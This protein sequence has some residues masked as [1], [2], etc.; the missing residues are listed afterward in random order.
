MAKAAEERNARGSH[1]LRSNSTSN[2]SEEEAD[3]DDV[4]E[5]DAEESGDEGAA[6]EEQVDEY[7]GEEEQDDG[8]TGEEGRDDVDTGEEEPNDGAHVNRKRTASDLEE[9]AMVTVPPFAAGQRSWEV[10]EAAL[11]DYM[12]RTSQVLVVMENINIQ[13]RNKTLRA[14]KQYKGKRDDE[15]PLVPAVWK[16]YQRKY[17]CTHGWGER[18]RSKT[19]KR[20]FHKLRRDGCPFQFLAQLAQDSTGV[21]AIQ[22]RREDYRHNHN[23]GTNIHRHYPGIRQVPSKSPLMPGI[24]LLVEAQAG[25]SKIYDYI[26]GHSMHRVTMTD[27][28][29]LVNRIR[30][31]GVQLSDDDAV[32]ETVVNFNLE[33]EKNVSTDNENARGQTGVISFTTAHMRSTVDSFPEVVQMDCTHKTNK[34]NYQLLSIVAMDQFG[35]GQPVQYSLLETTSDWHISKAIDHFKRATEHWRLV[36][37]VIVDKDMTEVEKGKYGSYDKDVVVQLK[38]LIHNLTYA[39]TVEQYKF[40]KAWQQR[41]EEE[42]E[43]RVEM[44]GTLRNTGYSEEMNIVLDNG[45]HV[46]V[47]ND[48]HE[49]QLQKDGLLCDCEFAQTMK[50]PC[51]H[52][53]VY[54]QSTGSAFTIPFAAIEARWFS[55]TRCGSTQVA[56]LSSP[57]QAK[58][59]KVDMTTAPAALTER[60]KFRRAQ[61]M[62]GRISSELAT[63]PDDSFES[64]MSQFDDW[65]HNLRNGQ[66]SIV[67]A[68]QVSSDTRALQSDTEPGSKRGVENKDDTFA[69]D[70]ADIGGGSD[71]DEQ[72][73]LTQIS[74]SQNFVKKARAALKEYNEGMRLRRLLRDK[75]VCDVMYCLE[76]IKPQFSELRSYLQAIH[77]RLHGEAFSFKWKV[78]S[79]FIPDTVRFRF[80]EATVDKMRE[81]FNEEKY[82]LN[83]GKPVREEIAIDGEATVDNVVVVVEK[84]G[85]FEREQIDAMKWLWNLHNV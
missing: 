45:D 53:M 6:E 26:R 10:F 75:D 13:R 20:K 69:A 17:I 9:E 44:P 47:R 27:V 48:A 82:T 40:F 15:I 33:C 3:G 5:A 62:F 43:S 35:H 58:L 39:K 76:E 31:S 34:Y 21:W 29:N 70:G 4:E 55:Q 22:L 56:A 68:T 30:A 85:T 84:V 61:Q 78:D 37:I 2:A 74:S 38:H 36:R 49:Y 79:S 80:P 63:F 42:Y 77:V 7:T 8:D 51:R 60:E 32:A 83:D 66:S 54:K 59:F 41:L 67:D 52:A 57:F 18:E 14:Q 19:G 25:N 71:I 28:R 81:R 1:V 23:V 64:A 12:K 11:K 72:E 16:L 24:E 73:P 50:L 46:L 65:W